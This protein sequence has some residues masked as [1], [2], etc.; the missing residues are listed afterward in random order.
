MYQRD[1]HLNRYLYAC[2]IGLNQHKEAAEFA[3]KIYMGFKNV[4]WLNY[5]LAMHNIVPTH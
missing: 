1:Y 4:F 2:L 5:A 3:S